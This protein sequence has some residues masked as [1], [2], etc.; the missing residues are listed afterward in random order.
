MSS[1]K[2]NL[3][4]LPKSQRLKV[5]KKY[6]YLSQPGHR[7]PLEWDFE[8]HPLFLEFLEYWIKKGNYEKFGVSLSTGK[9]TASLI[10]AFDYVAELFK[11]NYRIRENKVAR[12]DSALLKYTMLGLGLSADKN[13]P[14]WVSVDQKK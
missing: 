7:I 5:G 11:C 10:D 4:K 14:E 12:F 13:I 9:D 6:F 1:I 3:D 8:E 2:I